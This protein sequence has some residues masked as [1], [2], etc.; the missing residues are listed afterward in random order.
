MTKS[1][2]LSARRELMASVRQKYDKADWTGKG[3]NGAANQ[4]THVM[5]KVSVKNRFVL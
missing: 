2:S 3:K 1:M 4:H 5:P